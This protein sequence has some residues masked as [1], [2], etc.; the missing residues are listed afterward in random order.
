LKDALAMSTCLP[1][2]SAASGQADETGARNR[3]WYQPSGISLSLNKSTLL[4]E[5]GEAGGG[6]ASLMI[7]LST[8]PRMDSVPTLVPPVQHCLFL[9][10]GLWLA[11]TRC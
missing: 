2:T 7:M 6:G 11:E 1:V 9:P 10:E 4:C 3:I 5:S 8:L